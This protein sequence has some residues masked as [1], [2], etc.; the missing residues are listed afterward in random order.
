MPKIVDHEQRRTEIIYALWQ[1]IYEQ[2]IHAASYQAVA[3][4]AGISVGR[5]QHYFA[6]KQDLVRAGCQAIVDTAESVH[7][8][9][10][11]ALEPLD[12]LTELLIQPLPRT[13]ALRLGIS[14][15]YAYLARATADPQIR[16][17]FTKASRGTLDYAAHLLKQAGAPAQE[18]GRLIAL[19]NGLAQ[20][21]M[22]GAVTV[23]EAA[24]VLHQEVDS[25]KSL[26]TRR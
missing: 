16:E 24:R 15:W 8:E 23:D 13:E 3:R 10:T 4:A 7:F 12:A 9:R 22:V 20:A 11:E 18:A 1:V 26:S 17:I 25:L 21:A 19:S 2:G 5:I 14:V 6:S